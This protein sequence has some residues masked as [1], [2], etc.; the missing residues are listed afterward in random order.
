MITKNQDKAIVL[1]ILKGD[2]KSLLKYYQLYSK[3]LLNFIK[4]KT[5]SLEDAEEIL[6]NTLLSSLDALR[7]FTYRSSLS[8]FLHSIAKNKTIDFYRKKRIKKI[9]FSQIPAIEN[10]ITDFIGP[11]QV[12]EKKLLTEKFDS[13]YYKISPKYRRILTLKYFDGKS[14]K[15]ITTELKISFKSAES[16]LFRARRAFAK[17]FKLL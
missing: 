7:D 3:R 9:L 5:N 13:A 4:R 1:G 2:E 6:Q 10:I 16:M 12:Y 8:T 15:E 14:I 17:E 11:E